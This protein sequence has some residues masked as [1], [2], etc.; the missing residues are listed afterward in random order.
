LFGAALFGCPGLRNAGDESARLTFD[1]RVIGD[2]GEAC[3]RSAAGAL[4]PGIASVRV[5]LFDGAGAV[6][7]STTKSALE[8]GG[9]VDLVDIA[10]G[11]GRT[12]VFEGLNAEEPP[13]VVWRAEASGVA[14][15]A[16]DLVR[17]P[18]YATRIGAETLICA[19]QNR[20][21]FGHTATLLADGRVLVAGGFSALS[22]T[23]SCG[24]NCQL[25]TATARAEAYDPTRGT[26]AVLPSM[27]A[28][29]ALHAATL[30]A[31]GRV[32]IAGG[33][34]SGRLAALAPS[35][36]DAV[37]GAD[38]GV[39][40]ATGSAFAELYEPAANRWSAVPLDSTLGSQPSLVSPAIVAIGSGAV[41]AG[42]QDSSGAASAA[43][44]LFTSA[45]TIALGLPMIVAR[46]EFSLARVATDGGETLVAVGGTDSP[47]AADIE[48][49]FV[50]ADGT[51]D[52]G[53]PLDASIPELLHGAASVAESTRLFDFVG[54][55]VA[56]L[57]TAALALAFRLNFPDTPG[58]APRVLDAGLSAARAFTS[59]A[60]IPDGGLLVSGGVSDTTLA[61][62]ASM[63]AL[64]GALETPPALVRARFC[65]TATSLSDG[66]VLFVGGLAV[67]AGAFLIS[68]EA[69]IYNPAR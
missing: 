42:G 67:D 68:D 58:A 53:A 64:F 60:R 29:R 1:E 4:P 39:G 28:Q 38:G 69:E 27:T 30:L 55:T 40:G 45:G 44:Y 3:V 46:S 62:L 47:A 25:V 43:R 26:F 48:W 7:A 9:G 57:P 6:L 8:A 35:L 65:H 23:G 34:S 13:A 36:R 59:A 21:T 20:G 32:L 24:A 10:A 16:G 14:T 52:A 2:G 12:V 50:D 37:V 5:T 66:T 18:L 22:V 49:S 63:D 54:G 11:S 31:D 17:V 61:P 41:I 19:R 51:P 33:T 56:S 15:G